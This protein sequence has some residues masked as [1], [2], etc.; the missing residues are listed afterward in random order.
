MAALCDIEVSK[1]TA[2]ASITLM[3]LG[4]FPGGIE[5]KLRENNETST[6]ESGRRVCHNQYVTTSTSSVRNE[7]VLG[8]KE[9]LS[10]RFDLEQEDILKQIRIFLEGKTASQMIKSTRRIVEGLFWSRF[11]H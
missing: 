2:L 8:A 7:I 4:P 5:E 6:S 3:E 11:G 10:Q 9:Y 1:A